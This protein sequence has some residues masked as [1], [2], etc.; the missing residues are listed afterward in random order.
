MARKESITREIL[1]ENA[2]DILRQ[3]GWDGVTARKLASR[4]GCSTQ[5]IFRLYTNM[6]ELSGE[7]FQMALHRFDSYYL[8]YPA[9]SDVPFVNLGLAFIG[10]AA[11]EPRLFRVLFLTSDRQGK[12]LYEL[13]NGNT[14]AIKTELIRARNAGC[15]DPGDLFMKMW[16]FIHGAACMSITGDYY[17]DGVQTQKL[18]ENAYRSFAQT[19]GV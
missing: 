6:E 16:I 1:L 8:A 10:F 18:L 19:S 14:D 7:L 2:F 13:L 9:E 15:K 5:P 11:S 4:I 3:E 12:Q 17:L